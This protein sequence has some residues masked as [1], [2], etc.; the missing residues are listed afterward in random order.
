MNKINGFPLGSDGLPFELKCELSGPDVKQST[1]RL[2]WVTRMKLKANMI[3]GLSRNPFLRTRAQQEAELPSATV[4][5]EQRRDCEA[6]GFY[7]RD[8]SMNTVRSE[9]D[10]R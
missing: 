7:D 9:C 3:E 1:S 4:L 5:A 8:M 6:V 10:R 2:W